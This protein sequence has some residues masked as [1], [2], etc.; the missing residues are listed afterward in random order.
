MTGT[1]LATAPG[2]SVPAESVTATLVV[3]D[4]DGAAGSELAVAM[5]DLK[6]LVGIQPVKDNVTELADLVQVAQWRA[7]AGLPVAHPGHH[8]VFLGNAGTGK[9]TVARIVGR[10]L[11]GL[12]VLPH[13]RVVEASRSDLVGGFLGQTAGKT[14]DLFNSALGGVLFVD[15]AYSLSEG[16]SNDSY[17]M[18]AI[19]TLLKLMEDHRNDIAVIVAGCPAPMEQFLDSNP[20][21]RSRFNRTV[22]FP[23][24]LP[25]DLDQIFGRMAEADGFRV[26]AAGQAALS[27]ATLLLSSSPHYANARTVRRLFEQVVEAQ[28][29]R[30]VGTWARPTTDQLVQ[31]L[32]ADIDTGLCVISS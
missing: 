17:G 19:D 3:G 30:L 23:D 22:L 14:T 9:T 24:Y 26:D 27:V 15:E 1:E 29:K 12:G 4:G 32:T 13:G 6:A 18:E 7:A 21:L 2:E 31:L 10:I 25:G 8:M 28:A 11:T 16:G 5:A 20:G